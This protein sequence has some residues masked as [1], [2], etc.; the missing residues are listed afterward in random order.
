MYLF[1]RREIACLSVVFLPSSDRPNIRDT[2]RTA[3]QGRTL[4]L[5]LD[6][7]DQ[8]THCGEICC[9]AKRQKAEWGRRRKG[10]VRAGAI[11]PNERGDY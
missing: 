11:G 4:R 9:V 5:R 8:I 1:D 7:A 10:R 6:S 2:S 3:S